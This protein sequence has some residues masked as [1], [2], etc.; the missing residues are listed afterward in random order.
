VADAMVD[1]LIHEHGA[2]Q[3]DAASL[4]V[5]GFPA[6]MVTSASEVTRIREFLEGAKNE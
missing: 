5:G 6:V 3:V 1:E 4:I 2:Q